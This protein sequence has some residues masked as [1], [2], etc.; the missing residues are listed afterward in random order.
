MGAQ[1]DFKVK[2][3]NVV[4]LSIFSDTSTFMAARVPDPPTVPVKVSADIS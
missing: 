1:Y 4:G 2:A 3:K